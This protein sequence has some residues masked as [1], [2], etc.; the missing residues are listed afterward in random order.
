MTD[1]SGS[2]NFFILAL[3]GLVWPS[4]YFPRQIVLCSL[5]M[6]WALRLG[7]YLTTRVLA[8]KKDDRFDEIRNVW[9]KWALFWSTQIT[10]VWVVSL[11]VTFIVA[12]HENNDLNAVDYV[13]WTIF[14]L[15]LLIETVADWQKSSFNKSKAEGEVKFLETGL[16]HYSR[17]PNYFGEIFVWLGIWLSSSNGLWGIDTAYG[18]L[19]L[20]S[21]LFTFVILTFLSGI[22]PAEQRDDKRF[23]HL[24][25]YYEYKKRTSPLW[26]FPT[27]L[28]AGMPMILRK[29]PF[30]DIYDYTK[31][32]RAEDPVEE[33]NQP[34]AAQPDANNTQ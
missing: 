27:S 19:G 12:T 9:W 34:E 2:L 10:W 1:F 29:V 16:W 21:P 20:F 3:V 28:Y 5:Q 11:P 14:A 7:A 32:K 4:D 15:A 13:G 6:L 8:R 22:P 18:V 26:F 25:S 24:E 33:N 30:C 23:K 31:L 17:H